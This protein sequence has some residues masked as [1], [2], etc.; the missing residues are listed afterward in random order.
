MDIPV[1]RLTITSSHSGGPGGQNVNKVATKVEI[2]FVLEEAD[3]IPPRVR[4]RLRTLQRRRI[5][6]NGELVVVSSRYRRRHQNLQDCL[7]KLETCLE[8]ASRR[9]KRRVPTRPTRSSKERR[10]DEKR[11]RGAIKKTRG[12]ER[13]ED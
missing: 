11:R 4:E 7:A 5:N 8:A 1:E 10:L 3:W 9:Q 12:R 13:N 2:R 6:Q